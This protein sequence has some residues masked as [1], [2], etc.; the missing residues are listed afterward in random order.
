M[1]SFRKWPALL[2]AGLLLCST[3]TSCKKPNR[4]VTSK[5]ESESAQTHEPS[6]YLNLPPDRL[7]EALLNASQFTM[8]TESKFITGDT[9]TVSYH[10]ATKNGNKF[11]IS[12]KGST[13]LPDN[14]PNDDTTGRLANEYID[15]EKNLH[16]L[17]HN[18]KWLVRSNDLTIAELVSRS[19][20]NNLLFSTMSYHSYDPDAN[21]YPMKEESLREALFAQSALKVEGYMIPGDGVYTFFLVKEHENYRSEKTITITFTANDITFPD[22]QAP[23]TEEQGQNPDSKVEK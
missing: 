20:Y 7:G 22:V 5:N 15:L 9:E 8:V 2:M 4:V 21:R 18:G 13:D 12:T 6:P 17:Q 19:S 16:Y 11:Q 3:L 23:S 14:S 10:T 1:K